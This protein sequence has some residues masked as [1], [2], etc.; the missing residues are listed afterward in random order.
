MFFSDIP[1]PSTAYLLHKSNDKNRPAKPWQ[2]PFCFNPTD[3]SM[4]F[5]G[6]PE[7]VKDKKPARQPQ[8]SW[9]CARAM[10]RL[11]YARA[12]AM[13]AFHIVSYR[14]R[15]YILP[16]SSTDEAFARMAETRL[17]FLLC[18]CGARSFSTG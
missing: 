2:S 5:P 10:T 12:V 16:V 15:R 14:Y 1:Y 18:R 3:N 13:V 7:P 4:E 8:A 17:A 9:A 6:R 11:A